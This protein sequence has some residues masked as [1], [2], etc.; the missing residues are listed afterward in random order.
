MQSQDQTPKALDNLVRLA[1]QTA[2]LHLI[3]TEAS[4][5]IH[6]QAVGIGKPLLVTINFNNTGRY[7]KKDLYCA[8]E[9]QY[10]V[11]HRDYSLGATAYAISDPSFSED[12]TKC[13]LAVQL[14]AV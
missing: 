8:L 10:F 5:K 2:G 14:Y 1:R 11:A 6:N 4:E 7:T 12:G 3:R 9:T 13:T